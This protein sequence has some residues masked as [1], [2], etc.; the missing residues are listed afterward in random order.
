MLFFTTLYVSLGSHQLTIT[1][2]TL[3]NKDHV[4]EFIK[5]KQHYANLRKVYLFFAFQRQSLIKENLIPKFSSIALWKYVFICIL[6]LLALFMAFFAVA[7]T[8]DSLGL[9]ILSIMFML[10]PIVAIPLSLFMTSILEGIQQLYKKICNVPTSESQ[11]KFTIYAYF[12]MICMVQ[13]YLTNQW[14]TVRD[15]AIEVSLHGVKSHCGEFMASFTDQ[16][17]K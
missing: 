10:N 4:V 1:T 11:F 15:T 14:A 13:I 12:A 5:Y 7:F 2:V 3:H 17:S 6:P 8:E 16:G 9:I